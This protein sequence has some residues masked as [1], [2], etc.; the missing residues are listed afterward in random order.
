MDEAALLEKLARIE[1]L[2]SG[3]T[4]DGERVAAKGAD[5]NRRTD[6][7]LDGTGDVLLRSVAASAGGEVLLRM[8]T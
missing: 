4:T 2:F 8:L 6:R 3:A 7:A 1:A 5:V